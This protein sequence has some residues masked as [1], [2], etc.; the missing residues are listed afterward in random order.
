MTDAD[1]S[2]GYFD[3][4]TSEYVKGY[5]GQGWHYKNFIAFENKSDEVC[6]IS[7]L[8]D[9]HYTYADFLKIAKNNNSLA[10]YLFE[11][12]DWQSPET[13]FSDLEK[14]DE[15]DTLGKWVQ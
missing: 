5:S 8:Y 7:E 14:D 15:I 3:K 4:E 6:Y 12:V 10:S 13:L 9:T 11:M 2:I 1:D